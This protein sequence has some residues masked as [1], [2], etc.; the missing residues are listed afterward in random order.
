MNIHGKLITLRAV[1]NHDLNQ[2]QEWS[3]NPEVQYWLGGWHFPAS[4]VVMDSWLRKIEN[5]GL[6]KRFAIIDQ[7]KSLIGLA[8]LVN[9][10]WKDR[11]ATHGLQF[12][13]ITSRGKGYGVDV[14]FAMMRY[15]FE[16]LG[17]NR[18]DTTI[19]EY[20]KAS[21]NLFLRKCGWIKEGVMK[22]WYWRKN[23]Y[24]DKII[25]GITRDDYLAVIAEN[26]YWAK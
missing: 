11:N 2:L 9:I 22:N 1:E 13:N 24:W 18:L 17:L 19:I 4:S 12:G 25:V 10:N 6:N 7:D 15:A 16:E 26:N 14:V 3:N 8:N 23:R 21:L 5:D 20:N